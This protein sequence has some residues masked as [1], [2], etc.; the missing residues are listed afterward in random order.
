MSS[1][2]SNSIKV[3]KGLDPVRRRP[4]MYTSTENP[5]HIAQEI[6]DNSVDEAVA[7]YATT[8]NVTLTHDGFITI[9]DDGRGMPTDIH[10]EEHISGVEVILETLHGGGK[11]GD[12]NYSFSGGLHGVGASV[13]NA[14]S[15]TLIARIKRDG[16]HHEITYKDGHKLGPLKVVPGPRIRKN[17]TGT[18]ISFK[19]DSKYFDD[20]RIDT[21]R[22][23]RQLKDKAILC[24]SPLTINYIN[25]VKQESLTFC[26]NDGLIEFLQEQE[27]YE[28]AVGS[29]LFSNER[30]RD[31][32]QMIAEWACY[33]SPERSILQN[34]YVNLIP[35][36]LGGTHVNALRNG[37]FDGFKEYCDLHNLIP[38]NSKI[39]A[40]DIWKN[41]NFVISLKMKEPSFAGQLKERL[42]SRECAPFI[43]SAVKDAF[44][45][46][47]NEH[48]EPASELL[49]LVMSNAA[50]RLKS[51][52]KSERKKLGSKI[53]M[54]GKLTDC[55]SENPMDNE[56]FVVEGDSAGGSA[57][58]ARDRKTQAVMPLRG[59]ILNCWELDEE[60]IMLSE[61]IKNIA[62]AIGV[63][64]NNNDLSELRYGKICI[65]ADADSDGLHIATLFAALF[66]KHFR[67]V[68][69]QGHLYVAMPPLYRI[70]IGK[71]VFYA[72]DNNEKDQV[73]AKIKNEKL[74]GEVNVQRFKGLGE[75]NPSQL[76]ETTMDP[77]TRRLVKLSV[78]NNEQTNETFDMLLARKRASHRKAWLESDGNKLS[79]EV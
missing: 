30:I 46:F 25:E 16:K 1:Y 20:H 39:A 56:I 6:L 66:V 38:K 72:L 28:D 44:S 68:I 7:G 76:K 71:K 45:L 14:L 9:E 2:D 32:N 54:P 11:F 13:T 62:T 15:E 59:K 65:L 48:P 79:L 55:T 47:L 73:L 18:S 21:K 57:K 8:I 75:M 24:P 27:N 31:D 33:F 19:P 50:L 12:D 43:S 49:E 26:Y 35:T 61:E 3:L 78:N 34:A 22:L 23:K 77:M 52:K 10:E 41:T 74:R 53:V 5:N 29:I 36:A 37:L 40:D 64:P 51:S 4:G 63:S 17:E 60:K 67:A 70:D 42:S 69:E 58:Q